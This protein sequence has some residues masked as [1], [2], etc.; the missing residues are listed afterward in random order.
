MHTVGQVAVLGLARPL[1]NVGQ[2]EEERKRE[3]EKAGGKTQQ[4]PY[5]FICCLIAPLYP[6]G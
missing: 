5:H 1:G 4:H 3:K 2:Q 6:R